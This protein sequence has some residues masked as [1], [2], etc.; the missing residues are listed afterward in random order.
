VR[1]L[2]GDRHVRI[3]QRLEGGAHRRGLDRRQ[4]ALQLDDGVV[5]A[6]RAI[7]IDPERE[8][9][10][11]RVFEIRSREPSAVVNGLGGEDGSVLLAGVET[12]DSDL[13]WLAK[14]DRQGNTAFIRYYP[15]EILHSLP[16]RV[17]KIRH[18]RDGGYLLL[19]TNQVYKLDEA[20]DVE[21]VRSFYRGTIGEAYVFLPLRDFYE[22]EGSGYMLL[23]DTSPNDFVALLDEE[24]G[25]PGCVE[26]LTT[27]SPIGSRDTAFFVEVSEAREVSV[28]ESQYL[29]ADWSPP[30]RETNE[31]NVDIV[32]PCADAIP[33]P[34]GTP[35]P[36]AIPTSTPTAQPTDPSALYSFVGAPNGL[37]LGGVRGG[38]WVGAE[39]VN[40]ELNAGERF[41]VFGVEGEF[42]G[43]GQ[44]GS[45]AP[46]VGEFCEGRPSVIRLPSF[47]R[48]RLPPFRDYIGIN[49][50]WYL[51]PREIISIALD[52]PVYVA[53]VTDYLREAGIRDPQVRLDNA[54]RLD[55][56]GDGQD[57]VLLNASR[58]ASG[59]LAPDEGN[60]SVVLLRK[61]VEGELMTIPIAES[62]FPVDRPGE[63]FDYFTLVSVP[64]M[65]G[66]GMLEIVVR[67]FAEETLIYEFKGNMLEVVL[68]VPCSIG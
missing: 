17:V 35:T 16:Q 29:D 4:V 30:N 65:N 49:G 33:T 12:L 7:G 55:I 60:Y 24:N 23:S 13:I 56:E 27:D 51:F 9:T 61:I 15:Q 6:V 41:R 47:D 39:V 57:E 54:L 38:K 42:L 66:D 52:S 34:T 53:A 20:G 14:F 58:L 46:G 8:V 67:R 3:P 22:R 44:N 64:D 68:S 28:V 59:A 2:S 40:Q 10:W 18:A 5:G 11:K 37:I 25:V 26:I 21:W 62:V 50:P 19:A 36:V 48:S 1:H 63:P 31:S 32:D 45:P 43:E